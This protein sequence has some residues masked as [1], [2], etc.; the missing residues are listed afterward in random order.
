MNVLEQ[1]VICSVIRNI[2]DDSMKSALGGIVAEA[3]PLPLKKTPL[4]IFIKEVDK[5][6]WVKETLCKLGNSNES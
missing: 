1:K 5:R 6:G 2:T 4:W 3:N